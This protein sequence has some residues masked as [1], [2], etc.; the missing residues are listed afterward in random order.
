M[1]MLSREQR[2][3]LAGIVQQGYSASM[4]NPELPILQN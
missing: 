3:A 2:I 1:P 4:S